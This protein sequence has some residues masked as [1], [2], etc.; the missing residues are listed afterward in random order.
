MNFDCFILCWL[1]FFLT[2]IEYFFIYVS[3]LNESII[4]LSYFNQIH[5]CHLLNKH[6]W[7]VSPI[8]TSLVECYCTNIFQ[9]LDIFMHIILK[10]VP[11]SHFFYYINAWGFFSLQIICI[12][13]CKIKNKI[14]SQLINTFFHQNFLHIFFKIITEI[15]I[16]WHICVKSG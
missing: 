6:C 12:V 13:S 3:N 11:T 15:E 9:A 10:Q 5:I 4:F 14:I 16:S 7:G 2:N 8:R 1:K